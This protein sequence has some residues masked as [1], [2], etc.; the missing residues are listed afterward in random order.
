LYGF[1]HTRERYDNSPFFPLL[2]LIRELVQLKPYKT[3]DS[4]STF[5]KRSFIKTYSGIYIFFFYNYGDFTLNESFSF[6]LIHYSKFCQTQVFRRHN[7]MQMII[8]QFF[9]IIA[10]PNNDYKT[11]LRSVKIHYGNLLK[12]VKIS[13]RHPQ[14]ELQ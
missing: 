7:N 8:I 2:D 4:T 3:D 13:R 12:N 14:P 6:Q 10:S 1:E 9:V 11:R 5:H